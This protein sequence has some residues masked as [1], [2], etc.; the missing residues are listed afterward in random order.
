MSDTSKRVADVIVTTELLAIVL[1]M[2]EGSKIIRSEDW[3]HQGRI[4]LRVEHE[5]L[6]EVQDGDPIPNVLIVAERI[7]S[8]WEK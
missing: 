5:D 3:A 2:P 8:R 4:T 7:D 1:N 6:D